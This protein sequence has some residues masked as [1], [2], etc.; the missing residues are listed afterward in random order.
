MLQVFFK[1]KASKS[2]WIKKADEA[3]IKY[4]SGHSNIRSKKNATRTPRSDVE[5]KTL[6]Y[7]AEHVHDFAW[8]ADKRYEVMK[9]S[10]KLPNTNREV[11][12]W[13]LF[14]PEN[15]ALWMN[16]V[17]FADSGLW[18]YSKWVGD[19][20]YPQ[21][22]V[23]DGSL[24]AG[25]G[26]EYPMITVISEN[27]SSQ[28]LDEVIAHELGHNWFYGALAFNER[29]HPWMDEG[30]NTYYQNRYTETRYPTWELLNGV[31]TSFSKLF[32]LQ[33][34]HHYENYLGYLFLARQHNDQAMDENAALF[35]KLNYAAVVYGK[36]S[37]VFRYLETY[38]GTVKYDSIMQQFF[39]DWKFKHPYPDDLKAAFVKNTNKELDWV[40]NQL[41]P[42][43]D[44]LD[45]KL[46]KEDVE[47]KIGEK[48]YAQVKVKNKAEVKGPYSLL[49]TKM[50]RR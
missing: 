2:G 32:D 25:G 48:V 28:Q 5:T 15:A 9:S 34:P 3:A 44:Y 14:L 35:T 1:T 7:I 16:A 50:K 39:S 29:E 8:F 20:P 17:A 37:E 41:I 23:V 10:V 6:H 19:Y 12:T 24:G 47:N 45:Y 22:T 33:Y 38:L 49:L 11:T 36:T 40:F 18:Y 31:P 43:T 42:T 46:Q 26:M 30:I 13:S 4:S 21:A 27:N